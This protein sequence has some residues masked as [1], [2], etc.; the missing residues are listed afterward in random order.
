MRERGEEERRAIVSY[1][2]VS[3]TFT[4]NEWS[5]I[6][7]GIWTW[8]RCRSRSRGRGREREKI[9]IRN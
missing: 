7:S 9:E 3:L 4:M 6:S 8:R 2:I 5:G 1:C